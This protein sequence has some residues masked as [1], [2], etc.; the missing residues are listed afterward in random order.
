MS[1]SMQTEPNA[2]QAIAGGFL[3]V[4][5]TQLLSTWRACRQESL[6]A[7]DFR[8]WL[9]CREMLARRCTIDHDRAPTYGCAELAR[10]TGVA[11][12]RARASVRRLADAGLLQWSDQAIAFPHDGEPDD[13]LD[14][15]IGRGKGAL[16]IPRRILRFLVDG[17]RPALIAAVLGTLLRCLARGRG[18][19]KARGRIKA[20][21]IARVFEVDLRRVK[22]ARKQLIDLG[23]I[24]PEPTEQWAENKWGRVHHIDLAWDRPVA[25]QGPRLP[26]PPALEG[27][28]SPPP[29]LHPE[30][31]QEDQNQEPAPGG[32]AG[33]E[34]PEGAGEQSPRPPLPVLRATGSPAILAEAVAV[35]VRSEAARIETACPP[36]RWVESEREIVARRP[37]VVVVGGKEPSLPAPTL[38]DVRIEDLKETGR[39]LGLLTQAI[40]RGLVGS[41]EADRLRFVSAAE[42]ALGVGQG[43][44][45]GLFMHLVRGR[46]WGYLTQLDEDRANARLKREL[47][48]APLPRSGHVSGFCVPV[49][50][51][52]A[53]LVR[54]V[55]TSM[56]RAGIFRDPFP[57]FLRLNPCWERGRWDR[58]LSEL[59][60]S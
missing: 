48:G 1:L 39:L 25:E 40:V 23:W 42:H 11:E 52:D 58:A 7:G 8:T 49:L 10:L 43:N 53:L 30:P 15:T 50:S 31:F 5:V 6:G 14:D 57:A 34:I 38:N 28:R 17:A 33:V 12:K 21:W 4:P 26:P 56:M 29:D 47:Q 36:P 41:S 16:A 46:L 27:R 54:E 3:L 44:P 24:T 45:P 18:G 20:S 35:D 37:A 2:P 32:P 9:A 19:F 60:L 22:Q 13:A 59:G 55:R 51:P